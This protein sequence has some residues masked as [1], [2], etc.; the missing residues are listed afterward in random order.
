MGPTLALA[1]WLKLRP[2]AI[3]SLIKSRTSIVAA[4]FQI[5]A[6]PM[7]TASRRRLGELLSYSI[8]E[9][10]SLICVSSDFDQCISAVDAQNSFCWQID[11]QGLDSFQGADFDGGFGSGFVK[12]SVKSSSENGS[13]K[14][15]KRQW[16]PYQQQQQQW[17]QQQQV[18]Q[19][20]QQLADW[21]RQQQSWPYGGWNNG[22]WAGSWWNQPWG[23]W[24][25][26]WHSNWWNR[27]HWG[28]WGY[29][30]WWGKK[31]EQGGASVQ[32]GQGRNV[33]GQSQRGQNRTQGQRGRGRR[34]G[35]VQQTTL[36]T[37]AAGTLQVKQVT[38]SPSILST[39][40]SIEV[41]TSVMTQTITQQETLDSEGQGARP[42]RT[43][44]TGFGA[45]ESAA[46]VKGALKAKTTEFEGA[47]PTATL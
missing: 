33:T 5:L 47:S 34:T 30:G 41:N 25:R 40:S 28:G 13:P 16:W 19:Q 23:G 21:Q 11:R 9:N 24:N 4:F 3:K 1:L 20:Q 43:T 15:A 37:T 44:T 42:T 35:V 26:G 29:R 18:W 22:N 31:Q 36:P 6:L 39:V 27:P 10:W 12:R 17:Q 45:R 38:E 8:S 46:S 2:N 7:V 14:L 32:Q